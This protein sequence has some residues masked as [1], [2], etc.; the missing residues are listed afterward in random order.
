[1][2]RKLDVLYEDNH[3][4]AVYK[5]GGMLVQGDKTADTTLLALSKQYLKEK[6]R[7]PGNVF[8]GLVHRLDRP[9]SGVVLFARTSKA[10]SR[11]ARA[12]RE[13]QV[14][15]IYIAIVEGVPERMEDTLEN[16]I[17]RDLRRSRIVRTHSGGGAAR[18]VLH[19][20]VVAHVGRTSLVE[21]R[22]ETGRHH[23][24]RVQMSHLGHPIRG[25]LKYGAPCALPDKTI[26]LHAWKM[27]LEHPVTG[28]TLELAAPPPDSPPWAGFRHFF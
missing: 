13:R 22:P 24:I 20:R 9:V 12:F 11:L 17:I 3:L 23:Q 8:L 27:I 14:Q 5:D 25:D 6:Y 10:A 4:L 21:I 15:K 26:A 18:A 2:E 19:Y 7:K 1:M 28:E 16:H